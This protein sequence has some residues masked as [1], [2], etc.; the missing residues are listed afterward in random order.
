MQQ[1][2]INEGMYESEDKDSSDINKMKEFITD[3]LNN[4][5]QISDIDDV[6]SLILNIENL[7]SGDENGVIG[8]YVE[9]EAT[10]IVGI[11]MGGGHF[12]DSSE[13]Y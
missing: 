10:A 1:M 13:Y 9:G 3:T 6:L 5:E 8:Y 4:K 11:H 2:S 7:I 12:I